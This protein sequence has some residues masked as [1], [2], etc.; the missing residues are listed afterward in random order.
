VPP[1]AQFVYEAGSLEIDA[2]RRELRARG[3]PVP[4]GG[5]A[6]EIIEALVQSAG[7]LVTKD[8]LM[9][10]VWPG[11]VVGE[12]TI[13][14]HISAIRK[15]LGPD[16]AI[17]K[18][19]SGRG[20]RLLGRWTARQRDAREEPL[21]LAPGRLVAE[22]AQS[23]L[24]IASS[25]L[26]G[27]D[28][29]LRHV[30]DLISAYRVVTLTGP[31]GIGKTRLALEVART[32]LP[33]FDSGVW[34]IDLASMSDSSLVAAAVASVLGLHLGETDISPEALA[35]AVGRRKLLLVIDNCEHVINMAATVVDALVRLCPIVSVLATSRELL[36]IDGECTYRLQPL[37]F[38]GQDAPEAGH[39]QI[40]EMSAVRL[41]IARATT[42]H[43]GGH[44]QDEVAT[45]AAI[46]QRLDGIPLA[47]EFAA[48]RAAMLG[49]TEVLSRLDDRFALLTSGRRTALPKHRT[50]R[51]TL[52][53]SYE[54]LPRPERLLLWRLAIFT[55]PFSLEA[56][57]VVVASGADTPP[58]IADGIASLVLKSLVTADTAGSVVH[59]RL[60]ETTR[61]YA[62]EKLTEAGE[63]PRL[64]RKH[65]EYYRR[66][67]ES[68]EGERET[69]PVDL[70][71]LGNIRAALEWCFGA[72]GDARIGIGLAAAAGRVFLAM[73]LVTESYRWSRRALLALPDTARGGYE[74][75]HL[76]AALGMSLMFTGGENQA[77]GEA[78][79]K[80]LAIAEERGDARTQLWLL[81]TL[82][83]FHSRTGDRLTAL[84]YVRRCSEVS[85]AIG[86]PDALALGHGLL[87]LLLHHT[88]DLTGARAEFEAALAHGPG[89][90]RTS[91]TYLGFNGF[92]LAGSGLA[93][94]LWLL[95]HPVQAVERAR[96]TVTNAAGLGHPVTLSI[97]L[98][99]TIS[100][101]LETGD[102]QRA[103]EH[104]DW[105]ISH[106]Q[107]H[108]LGPYLAV[109]RGFRGQLALRR[110][111][112]KS[113]V[114][115]LRE[116]LAGL[117]AARNQL[118]KMEFEASLVQGLV[119]TG[120]VSEGIALIDETI[121]VAERTEAFGYMPEFLRIK[122]NALLAS[123]RPNRDGAETCFI[124]S[125]KLSRRQAA[126]AWEL[127]TAIDL[128]TLLVAQ[129][130]PK[131]AKALLRPVRDQ[132]A[133][134]WDTAD[135]MAAESLLAT[136]T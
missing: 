39:D 84:R 68:A 117:A 113:G 5:R 136:I 92:N 90:R 63:L 16:R 25:N 115:N 94:V 78:L 76:Q 133:E 23:N 32:L 34:L 3:V 80:S 121:S 81:G 71:D 69:K 21:D 79:H 50:L 30:R 97:A 44:G 98:V 24:P 8:D 11:A 88:G 57:N 18:T 101:F 54:L 126:R 27:R 106:A 135:L 53:W 9:A 7:Q 134:G 22:P 51:A 83:M 35:R 19:T 47:I 62:F 110:G 86:E 45:I 104:M 10:R 59:F 12:A 108:S 26:I 109:G 132:F 82:E 67:L 96:Q 61:A 42:W 102:L 122:G 31:G 85:K 131:N 72:S 43:S 116:C 58:D 41:F 103:E 111:D 87:G 93:R 91:T 60:L 123:S 46:C 66:L 100:V 37:D 65:A 20:Y 129:G 36:R 95:G 73:S 130:R 15:A 112:T 128:A 52:D 105:F 1:P 56:A 6:F 125:L 48:A 49:V 74:E 55:A 118:R 70:A 127:R 38:P 29:A 40:L 77:A 17:L 75:M 107:S 114:E 14:V 119:A 13:Q 4:I 89:S 33:S 28:A 99:W 2:G 120:H 64:A 124:R